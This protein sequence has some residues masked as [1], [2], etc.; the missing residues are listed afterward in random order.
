MDVK[1]HL[2][3]NKDEIKKYLFSLRRTFED[4]Y[5]HQPYI[6]SEND[7]ISTIK[8]KL[9]IVLKDNKILNSYMW[10]KEINNP[11]ET[12]SKQDSN[13]NSSLYSRLHALN[14]KILNITY[15]EQVET[16]FDTS[17]LTLSD[18]ERNILSNQIDETNLIEGSFENF[19][20]Y[21][22]SKIK[23][24]IFN[25]RYDAA[26][27]KLTQTNMATLFKTLE[28]ND[29]VQ[30][31]TYKNKS[32][33]FKSDNYSS[34]SWE[35]YLKKEVDTGVSVYLNIDPKILV[36]V[37]I[38]EEKIKIMISK[39]TTTDL[40]YEMFSL[41]VFNKI[42]SFINDIIKKHLVNIQVKIKDL[43]ELRFES[44]QLLY[45]INNVYNKIKLID[46]VHENLGH[47]VISYKKQG[48]DNKFFSLVKRTY[49]DSKKEPNKDEYL[50]KMLSSSN[51]RG[52]Y[53]DKINN[54]SSTI[55]LSEKNREYIENIKVE[56]NTIYG[57][58]GNLCGKQ[59]IG[60][61]SISILFYPNTIQ[62]IIFM[63]NLLLFSHL[64]INILNRKDIR[65]KLMSQS[66]E[67]FNDVDNN[68]VD[69]I[70]YDDD[71]DDDDDMDYDDID[72]DEID[73]IDDNS[74]D[75]PDV[76]IYAEQIEYILENETIDFVTKKTTE[77]STNLGESSISDQKYVLNRFFYFFPQ[78][79]IVCDEKSEERQEMCGYQSKI[80]ADKKGSS[81]SFAKIQ[82]PLVFDN[83]M[84]EIIVT[85]YEKLQEDHPKPYFPIKD[86]VNTRRIQHFIEYK[87]L[88]LLSSDAFCF[89]CNNA[90]SYYDFDHSK[91]DLICPV[92]Y[93]RSIKNNVNDTNIRHNEKLLLQFSRTKEVLR[94]YSI[95]FINNE[96][97][98]PIRSLDYKKWV[99]DDDIFEE[100]NVDKKTDNTKSQVKIYSKTLKKGHYGKIVRSE[101]DIF[102]KFMGNSQTEFVRYSSSDERSYL[103]FLL[104]NYNE[105]LKTKN[106]DG[107]TLSLFKKKTIDRINKN[108]VRLEN[109]LNINDSN[110]FD[111]IITL[112]EKDKLSHD[113]FQDIATFPDII[114]DKELV[115][116][117]MFDIQRD[118]CN[119]NIFCNKTFHDSSDVKILFGSFTK[120]KNGI[121]SYYHIIGV[122][123]LKKDKIDAKTSQ[124]FIFNHKD[125]C[126]RNLYNLRQ[127]CSKIYSDDFFKYYMENK[128]SIHRRSYNALHYQ[129]EKTISDF[130]KQEEFVVHSQLTIRDTTSGIYIR[131]NSKLFL[132][133]IKYMY[134]EIK[135]IPNVS[136]LIDDQTMLPNFEEALDF[137]KK[138]TE[139]TGRIV[140]AIKNFK[141]THI[142]D[143][144]LESNEV[145]KIKATKITENIEMIMKKNNIVAITMI[146][147]NKD[148]EADN[149][150]TDKFT[151][152]YTKFWKT[153]ETLLLK[154]SD[155][156]F[157]S[158]STDLIE[159]V[160][161]YTPSKDEI[162]YFNLLK[163]EI[164]YNNYITRVLNK[165]QQ[166]KYLIQKMLYETPPEHIISNEEK[167]ILIDNK[168]FTN[169]ISSQ[170]EIDATNK[171]FESDKQNKGLKLHHTIQNMTHIDFRYFD[172]ENVKNLYDFESKDISGMRDLIHNYNTKTIVNLQKLLSYEFNVVVFEGA[173]VIS[174][175]FDKNKES[176]FFYKNSNKGCVKLYPVKYKD[177]KIK[178]TEI[179]TELMNKLV[180]D[181]DDSDD[182]SEL[183]C[184]FD[185]KCS[186]DAKK[187]SDPGVEE[188]KEEFK[189]EDEE[190]EEEEDAVYKGK[191]YCKYNPKKGLGKN[192]TCKT[193]D[194]KK[195]HDAENCVYI[196]KTK[197]CKVK[198]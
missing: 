102:H 87:N 105:I 6:L 112:I 178:T 128:L 110:Y 154:L 126:F 100:Y 167:Q 94:G 141:G 165:E 8:K 85:N 62:E 103:H 34:K 168:F 61:N 119:I 157:E 1:V 125:K 63:K 76:D 184:M 158:K 143:V 77:I 83:I 19:T 114:F 9:S 4:G 48:H 149:D 3:V 57:V 75:V 13:D 151:D 46:F 55:F 142:T 193:H 81:F 194:Q 51:L 41:T 49:N 38:L 54:D 108:R 29:Y 146:I 139:F 11:F 162:D 80:K 96:N 185:K 169:N 170:I 121:Y 186:K 117:F 123:P 20:E 192:A 95:K 148:K 37:T 45:N 22:E 40:T 5:E 196:E 44:I 21:D 92:C 107:L 159:F 17:S 79:Q 82:V 155:E 181:D 171:F 133:P 99:S 7:K 101:N 173:R 164:K 15:N 27:I 166:P 60:N 109:Y 175:L 14:Y 160:N 84:K 145:F 111:N 2:Y 42:K 179:S 24:Q 115:N 88:N 188:S 187:N 153:Y 86:M 50:Q 23:V 163:I 116:I 66:T 150:I 136:E 180:D 122:P 132:I 33:I 12:N 70:D 120:E 65:E 174:H 73:D 152:D 190:E 176:L 52:E 35:S 56:D 195:K 147:N 32:K 74:E 138:H 113:T 131:H 58:K 64:K 197:R 90:L 134:P 161:K 16:K 106:R 97:D 26:Q 25:M 129:F 78:A 144:I 53:N 189:E 191:V 71:D 140:K 135:D 104:Y 43:K 31:I 72:V 39:D 28:V 118:S 89:E 198:K 47:Y 172:F 68:D 91:K 59:N 137:Y 10:T 182:D 156:F 69:D 67:S 30:I 177:V 130:I 18:Y 127:N 124:Q 93:E 98:Y 36:Q 183:L